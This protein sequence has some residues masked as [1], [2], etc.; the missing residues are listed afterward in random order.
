MSYNI[1]QALGPHDV[2]VES[3]RVV[4]KD[5]DGAN[6]IVRVRVKFSD[7]EIGTRDL[8]PS[9]G[10]KLLNT[11]RKALKAMAFDIDKRDLS[12]LVENPEAVKGAKVQ[13]V[14][15]EDEYNGAVNRRISW[16]NPIPKA[17]PKKALGSLTDALRNAKNDNA[18]E[19][20]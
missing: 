3:A 9:K 15:E 1:S 16:I 7:G 8:Y 10:P 17:P 20:L 5:G 18:A 14:V 11:T 19:A 13:V 2:E 6:I 12:E 4:D